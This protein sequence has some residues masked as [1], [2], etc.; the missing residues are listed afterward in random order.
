[1]RPVIEVIGVSSSLGGNVRGSELGPSAIKRAGLTSSLEELG[2]KVKDYGNI[3]PSKRSRRK[4][5][6]KAKNLVDILHESK[7][8]AEAVYRCIKAGRFPLL[9][10][11]DHSMAIGSISGFS[12]AF[13]NFVGVIY[14]DA[15]GDFNTPQTT[16]SGNVHGMP[17]ALVSGQYGIP[18][19]SMQDP[20]DPTKI[21]IVGMRSVDPAES[22]LMKKAGVV[23]V[24]MKEIKSKGIIYSITDVIKR[25]ADNGRSVHLSVDIDVLDPTYAQGTGTPVPGGMSLQD[26][27][28]ALSLLGVSGCVRSL[29]IA[30]VNPL[31]DPSG[32]TVSAA[33]E[34]IKAFFSL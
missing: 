30:E 27:K 12:R 15:H 5:D 17:L 33:V 10:G 25:V 16:P 20:I 18:A 31:K 2:L 21:A 28:N 32:A 4:D 9:L 24:D 29:E 19:L 23:V 8:I 1:M 22:G 3:K 6:P 11:G 34:L 7:Q 13:D 14:F 26:L